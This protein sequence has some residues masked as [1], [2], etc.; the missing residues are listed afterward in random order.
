MRKRIGLFGFVKT[1]FSW[2]AVA[3]IGLVTIL[4][5]FSF[6]SKHN[7]VSAL[8]MS[9]CFLLLVC[10]RALQVGY[11]N[12]NSKDIR[13]LFVIS[14][15]QAP[16]FGSQAV[17]VIFEDRSWIEIGQ[18]F[19]LQVLHDDLP[20][21]LGLLVVESRLNETELPAGML[22][23]KFDVNAEDCILDARMKKSLQVVP[24]VM[25]Q[26]IYGIQGGTDERF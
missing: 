23:A 11:E 24:F 20:Q 25:R 22:F 15:K 13:P 4:S 5:A 16:R 8:I 10:G 26:D 17:Y 12:F 3:V 18:V 19:V 2:P 9:A 21:Q 6:F 14:T 1:V 7:L